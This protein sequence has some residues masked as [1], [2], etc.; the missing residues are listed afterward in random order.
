MTQP[1]AR[2]GFISTRLKGTDGVSLEVR[3]WVEVLSGLQ[4]DCFFFAGE[5]DWPPNRSYVVPEAHFNHPEVL[6]LNVDLFDDYV[7][8][9]ETSRRIDARRLI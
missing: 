4:H 3:K 2:I 1:P 5:S 8:T 6:Q 9:P 7:R